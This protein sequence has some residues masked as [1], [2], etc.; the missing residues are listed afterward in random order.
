MHKSVKGEKEEVSRAW[1]I[2]LSENS[3]CVIVMTNLAFA[4]EGRKRGKTYEKGIRPVQ[5]L[6]I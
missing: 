3:R 4:P 1:N 2:H 5:V 6:S